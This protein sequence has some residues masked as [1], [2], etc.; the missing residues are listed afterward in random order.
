MYLSIG[1][2]K[3][4]NGRSLEWELIEISLSGMNATLSWNMDN[5]KRLS[6]NE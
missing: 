5:K 1:I 4:I 2:E 3:I 6:K